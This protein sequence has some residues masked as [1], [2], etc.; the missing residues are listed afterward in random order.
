MNHQASIIVVFALSLARA[1]GP[2]LSTA[3]VRAPGIPSMFVPWASGYALKG[4]SVQAS[5]G[6]GEIRFHAASQLCRLQFVGSRPGALPTGDAPLT[7][8]SMLAGADPAKWQHDSFA[9]AE[10]VYRDLY[11]GIDARYQI[12]GERLKSEF[13][14][15]PGADPSLIRMTYAGAQR[16]EIDSDGRLRVRLS[17]STTFI[18]SA[19]YI[20]QQVSSEKRSVAG[21]FQLLRDGSVGF[22]LG[23]YDRSKTLVID[24]EISY[25]TYLGGTRFDAAT[26][27][28][29]DAAGNS[30]VA[31]WT[32]SADFPTVS[33]LTG[34]RG[35][36]VDA[37]VAKL[38]P[39][40]TLVYA[41]YIGGSG[42][43]RAF[44]IAVDG[45]GAVY[46]TGW[47]TSYDFPLWGGLQRSLSGGKDAFVV[48]LN[49]AGNGLI[50][51][52]LFG[53]S[54]QESGYAIAIAAGNAY[55]TGETNSGDLT[56]RS[57]V[58]GSNRGGFD[59]FIAEFGPAG[60]A[61]VYSTYLGGAGDETGRGIAVNAAGEA[62]V[63]GGTTSVNFPTADAEQPANAGGED[64]FIAHISATGSVL[65]YSTY[66][67][68]NGGASGFSEE[69]RAIAVDVSGNAYIAGIANSTNFPVVNAFQAAYQGDSGDAF[70]AKLNAAG[71]RSFVT[72][73]GG[74]SL[75]CAN[76]I[77]V[78]ASGDVFIAGQTL[79]IDFPVVKAIQPSSAG[80][81]DAFVAE[82]SADGSS[83]LFS[84]YV[85]GTGA[86][87]AAGIGLDA[88]TRV[89][90]AGQTQ[91]N[92]LPLQN[93]VQTTNGGSYGAFVTSLSVLPYC[94]G[95]GPFGT[96][97]SATSGTLDMYAYGVHD[98]TQVLFPT[99]SDANGQD[100]IVWYPGVDL[101]GGTWKASIDLSRHRPGNPDMGTIFVHTWMI[102]AQTA[103]CG[104]NSFTRV[105]PPAPSCSGLSPTT[106]TSAISGTLDFYAYG[107]QN[108]TS[109]SFP[110]WS[111]VN[112]Q[113]DIVWYAG[114]N[115]GGGTWKASIDLSRHRPGNPDYGAFTTHIWLFGSQNAFCGATGFTRVQPPAPACTGVS[116]AVATTSA[117]SGTLELFAYGVQNAASVYFPAWSDVN[118]Q[119]DIVWYP[120]VNMG[121]GT[122]KG[123]IDLSRHRPGNPDYGSFSVHVWMF[124][125]QNAFCGI[126]GFTRR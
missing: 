118:G 93:P 25:S 76:A 80:Q 77:A 95:V 99:W 70:V 35:S 71:K 89:Y 29:V 120:G 62:F 32:E 107:V 74:R 10:L 6:P 16:V 31:G 123:S 1:G 106:I 101:G 44:G 65:L 39:A 117:T 125:S 28:A 50:Y 47:T 42:D 22:R 87:S 51:S 124:G 33:S 104:A 91:S 20:Y 57:A 64:A 30:Y 52:T 2:D 114:V 82:L 19:P 126:T 7:R 81:Y 55:I 58:Q 79:S 45:A 68:G 14:I 72:L 18:E 109:V 86:D 75:D 122:W 15:A 38:S 78:D 4:S 26:A 73:L 90:I 112:G 92:N 41:T 60:D 110:T 34:G 8:V 113:D 17:N 66:L 94:S 85:G 56:V 43:D 121:A 49:A 13:L 53:G 23:D 102:G 108:A 83:L 54:G 27:I 24:P 67:G 59:A 21:R 103:F 96:V 88:H 40:G 98:A 12:T 115:M 37:F 36:G 9:Y 111:N 105:P 5:F 46:L 61:L 119:D 97:T 48:K 11:P 84:S 100:D 63:T 3:A 116:P 69:G